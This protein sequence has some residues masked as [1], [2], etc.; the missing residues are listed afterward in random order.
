M[1]AKPRMTERATHDWQELDAR[2]Y[3]HPFTDFRA[4]AAEG[5]RIITRAEGVYLYD[6]D[7]RQILDGMSGLWCVNIGYGRNELAD[8]AARQMRE[9]PFY[10][11][12]F[13]SAHPPAIELSRLLAELTPPQF[14]RVFFTN[15]GSEANDLAQAGDERQLPLGDPLGHPADQATRPFAPERAARG[16]FA[17]TRLELAAQAGQ[18]RHRR[19]SAGRAH[20]GRLEPA[21]RRDG[22]V[23]GGEQAGAIG[24][25]DRW[26][27]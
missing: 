15:S 7:G 11:S 16:D 26:S 18:M 5:S 14:N 3:L 23:E 27:S 25:H 21:D 24:R 19:V 17:T 1:S 4:L 6:S 9:L 20:A 22:P 2:H 13:K 12:F 10:N 8:A